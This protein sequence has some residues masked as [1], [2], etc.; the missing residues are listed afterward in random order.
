MQKETMFR[1]TSHSLYAA[2]P[3]PGLTSSLKA[4]LEFNRNLAL[5]VYRAIRKGSPW[6]STPGSLRSIA[7]ISARILI[8]DSLTGRM[9][10]SADRGRQLM[11]TLTESLFKN[12]RY[13]APTTPIRAR[14]LHASKTV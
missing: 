8:R 5:K 14:G 4:P 11:P 9:G 3:A 13:P 10:R 7:P 2:G 6:N 12:A 1:A